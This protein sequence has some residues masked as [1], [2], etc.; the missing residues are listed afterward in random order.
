MINFEHTSVL[1]PTSNALGMGGGTQKWGNFHKGNLLPLPKGGV[2]A[3]EKRGKELLLQS[4]SNTLG[5]GRGRGGGVRILTER[6]YICT[7]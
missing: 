1:Y 7:L 6:F 4:T 3:Y 2:S 5:M